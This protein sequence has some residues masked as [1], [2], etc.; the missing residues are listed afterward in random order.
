MDLDLRL[1]RVSLELKEVT[2]HRALGFRDVD[3]F[4]QQMADA[5]TGLNG[6]CLC[7]CTARL[8]PAG[9]GLAS[10]VPCV[11]A[12]CSRGLPHAL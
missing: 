3:R 4:D 9:M 10:A 7:L 6:C 12:V 1:M 2:H 8:R 11:W 5:T